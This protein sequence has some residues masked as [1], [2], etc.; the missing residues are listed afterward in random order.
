[1]P[2][3]G[4]QAGPWLP[5]QPT[6]PQVS[7]VC[8]RDHF[9]PW[10][11][12]GSPL[13]SRG[14]GLWV[15][16][17]SPKGSPGRQGTEQ[18]SS[19]RLGSL[20]SLSLSVSI[21]EM[22]HSKEQTEGWE[23][24]VQGTCYVPGHSPESMRNNSSS[25][26]EEKPEKEAKKEPGTTPDP[27]ANPFHMSGDEDFFLLRR[28]ERD[29]ALLRRP[30]GTPPLLPVGSAIKSKTSS[31]WARDGPAAKKSSKFVQGTQLGQSVSN[32]SSQ[33]SS[34]PSEPLGSR[35][36]R[37]VSR[38][39]ARKMEP[40]STSGYV[41]QKRQLFLVQYAL[42]MKRVEIGRL[43]TLVA[44][45]EARLERAEK[46][47]QRDAALFDQ[48]L[49]DNDRSSVQAMRV[50]EKET[51]ARIEKIFEIQDLSSQIT[52]ELELYFTEPQQLLDVFTELEEQ[53]L[54]LTQNVQEM[55]ETVEDLGRTLRNTRSRMDRELKHLKQCISTITMAIAKEEETA[56]ELELKARVFHF[57]EYM[58]DEQDKLLDSLH[59][60]VLDVYRNCVGGQQEAGLGTVQMLTVIEHQLDELLENLEHVP[61]AKIEQAEKAKE[62]ERRV[63]LREEKAR[64]QKALQEERLL[65]AQA[66]AQA[67]IRKK[68]GRKL[69]CR[70]RPPAFRA[71]AASDHAL[72]DKA[73]EELL[74][75]FT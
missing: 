2:V 68:R 62:K 27:A 70:S 51:R 50:A 74:Y 37:L 8:W 18:A 24:R 60:K 47:L 63:R 9:S 4:G 20:A 72:P 13:R 42:E 7:Q 54:S 12:S 75:F 16:H 48:F 10:S 6:W 35:G 71:T 11:G 65:R 19:Q 14:G 41:D 34:Q 52:N 44:R 28:Q 23:Q 26:A 53:N 67:E 61:P 21:C 49:K 17:L 30:S 15:L 66:R 57:G 46:S 59:L 32:G 38:N 58:G 73:E 39:P 40:E 33:H 55:E 43:E 25:I 5:S 69:V 1:M 56:A 45:E 29:K 36:P 3:S 64:M 22:V 31:T